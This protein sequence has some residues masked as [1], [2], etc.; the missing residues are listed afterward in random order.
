MTVQ[1]LYNLVIIYPHRAKLAMNRSQSHI[2]INRSFIDPNGFYGLFKNTGG[3]KVRFYTHTGL[4]VQG[5]EPGVI[6]RI[7]GNGIPEFSRILFRTPAGLLEFSS[8]I[9]MHSNSIFTS[10]ETPTS[11]GVLRPLQ[12]Q[13]VVSSGECFEQLKPQLAVFWRTHCSVHR[14][15]FILMEKISFNP[16]LQFTKKSTRFY[17]RP[18]LN[19]IYKV[20]YC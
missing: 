19:N 16:T 8:L 14:N 6:L 5:Q 12:G 17:T 15:R 11:E 13:V 1:Q 3:N 4:V 10:Y 18:L 9:L 7:K 2:K 20:S